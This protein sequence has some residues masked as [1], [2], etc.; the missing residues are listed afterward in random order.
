MLCPYSYQSLHRH[1]EAIRG[2]WVEKMARSTGEV[3][4]ADRL[5]HDC[6]QCQ[7]YLQSL[8]D[9]SVPWLSLLPVPGASGTEPQV[10]KGDTLF[11]FQGETA[12]V[13]FHLQGG[14]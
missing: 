5:Y 9:M 8:W 6:K 7:A 2:A 12:R 14:M 3:D 4:I 13:E 11:I 1:S 10:E